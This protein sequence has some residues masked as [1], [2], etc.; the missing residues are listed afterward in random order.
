MTETN[1]LL[2]VILVCV[3]IIASIFL[4][5]R[6]GI[7]I[8][9]V[10]GAVDS[11]GKVS[12]TISVTGDGKVSAKPDMATV[13]LS[14]SELAATSKDALDKV[15][16]KISQTRTILKNNGIPDTDIT[17]SGLNIY[18]EYDYSN[19][20]RRLTGQRASE[21]LS[22]KVKKIDDKAA[23]AAKIIDELSTI[24]NVQLSGISF[25]IEDK[26]KLFSQARELAFNKA[27]Q[28]ATELAKLSGVSL[29]KPVSI[30]D[31]VYDVTPMPMYTNLSMKALSAP[32]GAG[33][34]DSTAIATGQM[35]VSVNLNIL[36]GIN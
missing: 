5:S 26:T 18:P 9:S 1:R 16:Q 31:T 4:A 13:G 7:Y 36:W 8:K 34:A 25:D 10:G 14:F 21:S 30:T 32:L 24:D 27:Q 22:V 3:T 6:T 17:T 19:N 29:A 20:V 15:N 28:K 33:A 35:D 2:P 23:K 12:N 11:S